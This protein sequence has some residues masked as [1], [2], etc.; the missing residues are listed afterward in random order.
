MEKI[1]VYTAIT[2]N[3]DNLHEIENVEKGIDYYCFTNNKNIKSST[4]KIIYVEDESLSNVKLAR[5]IKI[6][7]HPL[8]N[9]K[10]DI[11]VWIDGAVVFRKKVKDFIKTYLSKNDLIA[12][13]SHSVR[14]S[15]KDEAYECVRCG[16]ETVE[17]VNKILDYYNSEHYKFDNGLIESTVY[18]K[19]TNNTVLE[20]TMKLWFDMVLEYSKRDQLS[21]NYAIYKTG[22]KVKWIN[23]KVFANDWFEWI[24]HV[25][26]KEIKNYRVY[27]ETGKYDI[28]NEFQG[29]Y[30]VDGNKF[31][32]EGITIPCNT[33]EIIVN[34]SKVP[35]LIYRNIRINNKYEKIS[36]EN[37]MRYYDDYV[38][39]SDKQE[40]KIFGD[41]KKGQKFIFEIELIKI[42]TYEFIDYLRKENEKLLLD[43]NNYSKITKELK[44]EIKLI[45][46]SKIWKIAE[47]IRKYK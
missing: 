2:G 36:I 18:I 8:I 1:C 34:V 43:I 10:Y 42:D 17:N 40:I 7:G 33:N 45:K 21:F 11:L 37:Y 27:F 15:I 32:I 16:K 22:L 24:S 46:N 13:F 31:I 19:R 20:K 23:E 28:N 6:L 9:E 35:Y 12:A 47:K 30:K 25:S 26:E 4:W 5:K 41:F 14:N 38:F 29:T 3:Y 44:D 39:Y